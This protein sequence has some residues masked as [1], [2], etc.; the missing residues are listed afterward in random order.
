MR[1]VHKISRR[2]LLGGVAGLG[3]GV[4]AAQAPPA[5]AVPRRRVDQ[6][7]AAQLPS[8]GELVVR[9]AYVLTMDSALGDLPRGDVHVRAGEI[10]A[11]GT[12]LA[13]P[14]AQVLDGRDMIALPGLVDTHWH[15][16][17]SHL[18]AYVQDGAERGYFPVVLRLGRE[19]TPEDTYRGVRLGLAEALD[20]GVTTVHDWSHNIRNAEHADA[21]LRAHADVGLRARFSYGTYQGYPSDQVMDLAD[22]ARVQREWFARS[23]EGLVTLGMASRSLSASPRGPAPPDVLRRDWD[24][25]R[26][27]GLPITMH[28]SPEGTVEALERDR[29]LG[30]DLQLVHCTRANRGERELMAARGVTLSLSPW[31]ELR[32]ALAF[33]PLGEMLAAGVLVSLSFDSPALSGNAD[34]FATMRVAADLEYARQENALAISPRRV[35]EL[36]TIDGARDLGVADRSGSLTP[37]KRA[38]LILVR[39]TD[40]NMVPVVDPVYALVHSALPSNVDTVI[41]D[42]RILKRGGQLTALDAEQ[43]AREAAESALALRG[44]AGWP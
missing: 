12:D 38:D 15:M 1:I 31:S 32:A 37:G 30:P 5:R 18:R 28:A 39:T 11:V 44:R 13:A 9:G 29:L 33:P 24:G 6:R 17:N 3:A 22:L 8:R 36:A 34:M 4:L 16:W 2:G 23:G 14:G 7:P 25:A 40:L 43:V 21:D 27:L 42:G 10:V 35:L 41:V 26:S 20:S 19:F